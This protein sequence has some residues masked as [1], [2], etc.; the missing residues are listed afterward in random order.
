[1]GR[2]LTIPVQEGSNAKTAVYIAPNELMVRWQCSRSQ[3]DRIARREGLT[4]LLL[5]VGRNGMVR[6]VRAEVEAL[7]ERVKT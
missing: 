6:Y 4:R 1:M 5:G 3:V 2:G 7:E